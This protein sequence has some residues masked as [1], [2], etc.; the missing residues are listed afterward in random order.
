MLPS[1]PAT[2]PETESPRLLW[3]VPALASH[4]RLIHSLAMADLQVERLDYLVQTDGQLLSYQSYPWS[5]NTPSDYLV[6]KS[7]TFML[8][9][10]PTHP[11]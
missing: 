10:T 1:M 4:T 7:R 5:C 6:S 8:V 11:I 3:P 9:L 2:A